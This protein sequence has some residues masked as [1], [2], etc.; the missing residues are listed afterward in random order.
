MMSRAAVGLLP[1]LVLGQGYLKPD[2]PSTLIV[3]GKRAAFVMDPPELIAGAFCRPPIWTTDGRYVVVERIVPD[4]ETTPAQLYVARQKSDLDGVEE[5]SHRHEIVAWSAKTRRSRIVLTFDPAQERIGGLTPVPGGRRLYGNLTVM[6]RDPA[7][8]A[9]IRRTG[10]VILE[11]ESGRVVRIAPPD[12][13]RMAMLE[14]SS[15]GIG[16]LVQHD[17]RLR[18]RTV[19]FVGLDGRIGTPFPLPEGS[20]FDF[21]DAGQPAVRTVVR[22]KNGKRSIQERLLNVRLE[23]GS[24]DTLPPIPASEAMLV[25]SDEP[26]S[27]KGKG[28]FLQAVD[29]D[30]KA[31]GVVT[32]DGSDPELSP[33]ENAVAYLS[34]GSAFVRVLTRLSPDELARLEREAEQAKA[35]D[36]AK[37]VG[38]ALS[39]YAADA[40]DV[41]PPSG[42]D[43]VETVLP[44]AKSR[45]IFDGFVYTFNGA[46][47]AGDRSGIILGYVS[48]PGGR[49]VVHGDGSVNW[50]SDGF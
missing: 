6:V 14:F 43:L 44:Y 5:L 8:G 26:I 37:K 16:A 27:A 31:Y 2:D 28:I 41:M 38:L 20:F 18:N 15:Q 30:K 29:G 49:A 47:P 11:P 22:D 19:A 39:M 36:R 46:L 9:S 35:M 1:F 7:S 32:G 10:F 48:A 42:G 12:P 50:Q 40:D 45:A 21:N 34:S 24:S 17:E 25:V 33:R 13:T 3:V 4:P 23:G